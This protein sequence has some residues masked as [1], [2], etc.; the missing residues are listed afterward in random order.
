[1][2]LAQSYHTQNG[3][4]SS[5]RRS[6][7]TSHSYTPA[8]NSSNYCQYLD[9]NFRHLGSQD[10]SNDLLKDF[11]EYSCNY[12]SYVRPEIEPPSKRRKF[13]SSS[14]GNNGWYSLQTHA[15]NMLPPG[16]Q[17]THNNVLPRN[18]R[19]YDNIIS[20]HN[21]NSAITTTVNTSD[22]PY[23]NG[24]T[25]ASFKYNQSEFEGD[26]SDGAFMSREEIERCSPSRKDGIDVVLEMHLR[27]SYCS[28]LQS[29]GT[30]LEL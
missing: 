14:W 28:F 19:V 18:Q 29:L 24:Y 9:S 30:R 3:P 6:H 17:N 2:A 10:I 11:R 4:F 21:N 8:T 23:S 26:D 7:V 27:Y 22:V 5:Y 20:A 16:Q 1:M 15:C 12:N 13:S 25:S